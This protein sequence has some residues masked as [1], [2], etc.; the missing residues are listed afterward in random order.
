MVKFRCEAALVDPHDL[1]DVDVIRR[2]I[3]SQ[4]DHAIEHP[5][6]GRSQNASARACHAQ[7]SPPL[8]AG[9]HPRGRTPQRKLAPRPRLVPLTSTG[10]D[11]SR[12]TPRKPRA[13]HHPNGVSAS[14]ATRAGHHRHRAVRRR[15]NSDPQPKRAPKRH[16]SRS[17][18]SPR[19]RCANRACQHVWQRRTK[20]TTRPPGAGDLQPAHAWCKVPQ[21]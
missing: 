2:L 13:R 5:V 3:A 18:R 4:P 20:R 14:Q 16:H 21:R 6:V 7:P 9:S 15:R 12:S 10:G 11:S 8:P 1:L 19:P 17:Q